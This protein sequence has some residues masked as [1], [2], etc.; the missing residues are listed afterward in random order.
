MAEAVTR[1]DDEASPGKLS[2]HKRP[3]NLLYSD[4]L[5]RL[6]VLS[7]NAWFR[8]MSDSKSGYNYYLVSG[9]FVRYLIDHYGLGKFKLLLPKAG[10]DNYR[11]I[12]QEIYSRSIDDFEEEWRDFLR[13]Y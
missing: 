4:G 7:D 5:P 13:C 9:S 3:K 12:S 6:E 1:A 10:E 11:R 8:K 2:L